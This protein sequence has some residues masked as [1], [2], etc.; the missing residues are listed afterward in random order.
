MGR[1]WQ[2]KCREAVQ[3]TCVSGS[4]TREASSTV[5]DRAQWRQLVA[6]CSSMDSHSLANCDSCPTPA[7]SEAIEYLQ[8][9]PTEIRYSITWTIFVYL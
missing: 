9:G 7:K 1:T 3:E 8:V 2:D 5:S 6:Q 4:D